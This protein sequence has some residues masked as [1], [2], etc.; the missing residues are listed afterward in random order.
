[1]P[2][3]WA[4]KA[5]RAHYQKMVA[6][7]QYRQEWVDDTDQKTGDLEALPERVHA[8]QARTKKKA[9]AAK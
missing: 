5:Q 6:L 8:R 7:G 1:M 3:V 2:K 9:E 4:S